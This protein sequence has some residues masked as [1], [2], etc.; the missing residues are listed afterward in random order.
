MAVCTTYRFIGCIDICYSRAM[1]SLRLRSLFHRKCH[2][3]GLEIDYMGHGH[4]L[5][6]TTQFVKIAIDRNHKPIHP[7]PVEI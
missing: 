1:G 4:T 5:F 6:V 7:I 3:G 2:L